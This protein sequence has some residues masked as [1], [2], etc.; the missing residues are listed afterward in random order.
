ME[1]ES[2]KILRKFLDEL[3]QKVPVKRHQIEN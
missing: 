1:S 3:F 2:G